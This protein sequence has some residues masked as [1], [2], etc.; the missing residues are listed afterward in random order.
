MNKYL[1]T[2]E[3]NAWGENWTVGLVELISP[4]CHIPEETVYS[5]VSRF[6]NIFEP[7]HRIADIL[8]SVKEFMIFPVQSIRRG[9]RL[10]KD[11]AD[12]NNGYVTG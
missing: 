12:K 8:L 3:S 4:S 5:L 7:R 1:K 2:T 6:Q 10:D 9:I 11:L